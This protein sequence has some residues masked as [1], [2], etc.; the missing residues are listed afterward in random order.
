[1]VRR[2]WTGDDYDARVAPWRRDLQKLCASEG[3]TGIE[4]LH[5]YLGAMG[6]YEEEHGRD[7]GLGMAMMCAA[8]VDLV[9]A[10]GG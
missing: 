1:M 2:L 7:M 6:R 4:A 5:D 3:C 10:E 9:E 8:Y